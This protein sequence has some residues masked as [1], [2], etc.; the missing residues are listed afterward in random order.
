MKKIIKIGNRKVGEGYPPYVI[1]E[2]AIS[3]QGDL[4]TAIHMVHVAH[5]MGCDA[6]K[7]QLH[8]L[9]NEMLRVAPQSDNFDEPLWDTLEKTIK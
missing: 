8:V 3:H 5:A 7:F 9:D 6:I 1:A 4:D 2:A